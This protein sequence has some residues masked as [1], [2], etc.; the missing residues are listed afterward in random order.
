MLTLETIIEL[1]QDS[2]ISAVS[3]KTGLHYNTIRAVRDGR[4]T[5]PSYATIKALS[6]YFQAR[7]V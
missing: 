6:D 7:S 2:R 3:R 5:S 4:A 1:L